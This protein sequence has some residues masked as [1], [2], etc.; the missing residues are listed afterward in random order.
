LQDL[1]DQFKKEK[2]QLQVKINNL[3]GQLKTK[4]NTIQQL[5]NE[6][7]EIDKLVEEQKQTISKLLNE[8]NKLNDEILKLKQQIDELMKL[9]ERNEQTIRDLNAQLKEANLKI[10]NLLDSKKTDPELL[11]RIN[12]LEIEVLRYQDEIKVIKK[13]MNIKVTSLEEE[14]KFARQTAIQNK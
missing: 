11:R 4:D 10:R 5:K 12:E 9:N 3:V 1:Q 6:R 14:L 13:F 8:K 7:E 2:Q